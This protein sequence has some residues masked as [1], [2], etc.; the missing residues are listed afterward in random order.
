LRLFPVPA[1]NDNFADAHEITA[2]QFSDWVCIANATTE[3]GEPVSVRGAYNK[4]LW[5]NFV[6]SVS[7]LITILPGS[8]TPNWD[9]A[10]F[11]GTS[12][13]ALQEVNRFRWDFAQYAVRAGEP[14]HIRIQ[15]NEEPAN[16]SEM[17]FQFN[18][19]PAN[20][21]FAG[22][23]VL[24]GD[25]ARFAVE[26][27]AA[28]AEA[29]EPGYSTNLHSAWWRWTPQSSGFASLG[30]PGLRPTISG[31]PF[32]NAMPIREIFTGA[33]L[34][35]LSAIATIPLHDEVIGFPVEA[36]V[37]YF[38][39][40]SYLGQVFVSDPF[41][42]WL[43]VGQFEIASP[44]ENAVFLLPEVP[45]FKLAGSILTNSTPQADLVEQTTYNVLNSGV[46]M[47]TTNFGTAS[48]PEFEFDATN[49]STGRKRVF[50]RVSSAD[51]TMVYT[52]P[53]DFLL[54]N[55][56]HFQLELF[57]TSEQPQYLS[58]RELSNEPV[59][60]ESSVDLKTWVVESFIQSNATVLIDPRNS[61]R[62]YRST[63]R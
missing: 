43:S 21:Q 51:G 20:D 54:V 16:A 48:W 13:G 25:K 59:I 39:R 15:S 41:E 31:N 29:G 35:E 1:P 9:L 6:P 56:L 57:R 36:G 28:T 45:R 63:P 61:R 44:T 50:A 42:V 19:P 38:V 62:F 18:G 11:S 27:N 3:P 17:R 24:A 23:T 53:I 14:Y 58:L 4:S 26:M 34:G 52:P 60:V 7:G 30:I 2:A 47:N 10:V 40:L 22:A 32:S 55:T 5:Y 12:L 8:G 46:W 37:T 49:L 33:S